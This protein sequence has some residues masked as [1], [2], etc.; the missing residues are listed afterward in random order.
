MKGIIE[1]LM[2]AVGGATAFMGGVWVAQTFILDRPNPT[3]AITPI[4][5]PIAKAVPSNP[6]VV[7]VVN[8]DQLQPCDQLDSIARSGR[9]VSE[10]LVAAN[11][12]NDLAKYRVAIGSICPWNSEQLA[13]ADRIINP[14]VV[15][16]PS[17]VVIEAGSTVGSYQQFSSGDRVVPMP[18]IYPQ[19]RWN[20]CDGTIDPGESY[21]SNCAQ[22]QQFNDRVRRNNWY[23]PENPIDNRPEAA[24]PVPGNPS[25]QDREYPQ[26]WSSQ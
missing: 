25:S 3:P 11:R 15:V 24:R 23:V 19:P 2:L 4:A 18:E 1:G 17:P 22:A 21:S 20:N 5:T 26:G 9:P 7:P 16:L 13:V 14:P 10:F 12:V 6:V 8:F